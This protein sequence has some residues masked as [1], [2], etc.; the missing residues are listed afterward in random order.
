[1]LSLRAL[2]LDTSQ[3]VETAKESMQSWATERGLDETRLI[4]ALQRDVASADAT[5]RTFASEVMQLDDQIASAERYCERV[6]RG[7]E[8]PPEDA[9]WAVLQ[10][11]HQQLALLP[12]QLQPPEEPEL[13]QSCFVK[14]LSSVLEDYGGGSAAEAEAAEFRAG[15]ELAQAKQAAEQRVEELESAHSDETT[16]LRA[17]V[18][19]M[20]GELASANAAAERQALELAGA[21]A[22]AP[23]GEATGSGPSVREASKL[24]QEVS[25]LEAELQDTEEA[26]ASA[27]EAARVEAEHARSLRQEIQRMKLV[28]DQAV[29]QVCPQAA[30]RCL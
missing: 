21:K 12:G 6:L 9:E 16:N 4:S 24:R 28:A 11:Q 10:S 20:A 15:I 27:T 29:A 5:A 7:V 25:A 23:E 3:S 1:M 17:E 26:V 8:A 30:C 2:R 14:L 18:A 19:A 22:A 13:Q